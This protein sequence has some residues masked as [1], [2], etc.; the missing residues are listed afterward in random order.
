MLEPYFKQE[1]WTFNYFQNRTDNL[2]KDVVLKGFSPPLVS[3]F[4]GETAYLSSFI[5][6]QEVA[7]YVFSLRL[8]GV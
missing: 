5:P 6:G 7:N 1:N 3:E 4:R 2:S 8:I